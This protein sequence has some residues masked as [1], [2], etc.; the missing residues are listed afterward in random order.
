ML[1]AF[2]SV[3]AATAPYLDLGPRH[4]RGRVGDVSVASGDHQ[5]SAEGMLLPPIDRSTVVEF[6]LHKCLHL[7][8]EVVQI[9]VGAYLP[10]VS[11]KYEISFNVPRSL[12]HWFG[13]K[14]TYNCQITKSRPM[15]VESDATNALTHDDFR[16]AFLA[17][18]PEILKLDGCLPDLC[19]TVEFS[20][21]FVRD[22]RGGALTCDVFLPSS[23]KGM[24]L[25]AVRRL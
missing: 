5:R 1:V 23:L 4:A 10:Q 15:G 20:P 17:L 7:P 16:V 25:I 21:I 13:L 3:L 19:E 18:R 9:V 8:L 14:S 12:P 22:Y 11:R 2:A 6:A 24:I